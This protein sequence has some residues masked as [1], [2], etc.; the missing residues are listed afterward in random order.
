MTTVCQRI[1]EGKKKHVMIKNNRVTYLDEVVK[2]GLFVEVASKLRPKELEGT[3]AVRS[4]SK[5]LPQR[6]G[7][8]QRS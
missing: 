6:E 8:V 2:E 4:Q 3:S 5:M 7:Q 1:W